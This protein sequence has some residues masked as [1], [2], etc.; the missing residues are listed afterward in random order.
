MYVPKASF[1]F[2]PEYIFLNCLDKPTKAEER[3]SNILCIPHLKHGAQQLTADENPD[4]EKQVS[5]LNVPYLIP[6]TAWN[7]RNLGFFRFVRLA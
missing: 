3:S 4:L 2:F 6:S 1:V 7:C 5:Y